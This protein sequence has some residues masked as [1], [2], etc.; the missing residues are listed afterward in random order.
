M[1]EILTDYQGRYLKF[2]TTKHNFFSFLQ[3]QGYKNLVSPRYTGA[4]VVYQRA[5]HF[6]IGTRHTLSS[7]RKPIYESRTIARVKGVTQSIVLDIQHEKLLH[8]HHLQRSIRYMVT[9]VQV[10]AWLL[11]SVLWE[12]SGHRRMSL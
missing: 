7:S 5:S 11:V 8:L 6:L 3:T 10:S 12:S 4:T 9:T 1:E 2:T